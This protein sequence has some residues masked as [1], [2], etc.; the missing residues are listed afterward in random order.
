M[1]PGGL[2]THSQQGALW[3][4]AQKHDLGPLLSI[5]LDLYPVPGLHIIHVLRDNAGMVSRTF[6]IAGHKDIVGTAGDAFR[7]FHHVGDRFTEDR[8]PEGIYR[9]IPCRKF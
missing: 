2:G 4:L 6:E 9:V 8:L 3:I 7:V 5:L 1:H